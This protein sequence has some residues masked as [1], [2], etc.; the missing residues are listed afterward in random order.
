MEM[1]P[2]TMAGGDP[3]GVLHSR[4]AATAAAQS[5]SNAIAAALADPAL[6]EGPEFYLPDHAVYLPFRIRNNVVLKTIE[7]N[8]LWEATNRELKTRKSGIVH[9]LE[10]NSERPCAMD[11]AGR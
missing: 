9:R 10:T 4:L 5:S 3:S 11:G 2:S 8:K 6:T 1:L 7:N